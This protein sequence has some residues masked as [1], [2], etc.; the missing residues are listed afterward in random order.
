MGAGGGDMSS[1]LAKISGDVN[2]IKGIVEAQKNIEED[3]IDDARQAR[4]KEKKY[5]REPHG[6]WKENV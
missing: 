1:V 4:E 6:R 3:K 5:G 2:I